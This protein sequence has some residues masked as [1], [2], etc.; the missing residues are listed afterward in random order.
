[1]KIDVPCSAVGCNGDCW[2]ICPNYI[3]ESANFIAI[4]SL[5]INLN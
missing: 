4:K 3:A 2:K 1:M 5:S